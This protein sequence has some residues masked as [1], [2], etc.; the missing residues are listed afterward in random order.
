ML[1]PLGGQAMSWSGRA[2]REGA[3]NQLYYELDFALSAE[4]DWLTIVNV[5]GPA[6]SGQTEFGFQA[7]PASRLNWALIGGGAAVVLAAGWWVLNSRSNQ[8]DPVH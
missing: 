5:I 8:I 4:G 1:E 3:S 6:G 2:S 7:L